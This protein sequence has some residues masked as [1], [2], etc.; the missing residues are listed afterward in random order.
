M[1]LKSR[2][3]FSRLGLR[4]G[5]S[6][7]FFAG[8][9][10]MLVSAKGGF[11]YYKIRSEHRMK[12]SLIKTGFETERTL[13][14]KYPFLNEITLPPRGS[15]KEGV[16]T[17]LLLGVDES[18]GYLTDSILVLV[19]DEPRLK[20]EMISLPRDLYL[21]L[22]ESNRFGKINEV[23]AYG[24]LKTIKDVTGRIVGLP[25]D[26]AA[27]V[28]FEAFERFIDEIGGVT[29]TL[30][31]P[32]REDKQWYCDAQG[33]CAVF[34]IPAG[35]HVLDGK[36]ALLYVRSRFSSSDFD[37]ARRQQ[38]VALAIKD[39]L[40]S[41]GFLANPLKIISLLDIFGETVRTDVSVQDIWNLYGKLGKLRDQDITIKSF[42]FD[43]TQYGGLYQTF[44]DKQ[45][46]LLP[47]DNDYS[48]LPELIKRL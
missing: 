10:L 28:N 43:T 35:Q 48:K 13:E 12:I 45:Y 33:R 47:V 32:F 23:Y 6:I 24:G 38:Q 44:I 22:P 1:N 21:R 26:Y 39:K 25:I 11:T 15:G 5:G 19:F 14:E 36:T 18:G 2:I 41:L 42:V 27:V 31:E 16:L 29:I 7:L 30:A 8:I 17:G 37:R 9:T 46:V 3:N 34:E 20:L 40:N 4:I